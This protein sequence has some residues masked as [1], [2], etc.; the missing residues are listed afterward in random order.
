MRHPRLTGSWPFSWRRCLWQTVHPH[1][2][3]IMTLHR[4]GHSIRSCFPGRYRGNT[5]NLGRVNRQSICWTSA[6]SLGHAGLQDALA[7]E[8]GL[9]GDTHDT[10]ITPVSWI[11][12]LWVTIIYITCSFRFIQSGIKERRKRKIRRYQDK[13]RK[14]PFRFFLF[15]GNIKVLKE[16]L[17][18]TCLLSF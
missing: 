18:V 2:K 7:W 1:S 9:P 15:S 3:G 5:H 12:K 4:L 10:T 11:N 8:G 14:D 16:G 17:P 6:P 13:K